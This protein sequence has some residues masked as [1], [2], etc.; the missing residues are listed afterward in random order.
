MLQCNHLL[1]LINRVVGKRGEQ[2]CVVT[3]Y[4]THLYSLLHTH[5]HAHRNHYLHGHRYRV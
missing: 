4:G 5:G 3:R 1:R 2:L